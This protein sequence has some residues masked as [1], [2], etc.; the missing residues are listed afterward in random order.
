MNDIVRQDAGLVIA[1]LAE[2]GIGVGS[3]RDALRVDS[4]IFSVRFWSAVRDAEAEQAPEDVQ[5][6]LRRLGA[7]LA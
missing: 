4:P 1:W 3:V 5:A 7:A 2:Q 6:A